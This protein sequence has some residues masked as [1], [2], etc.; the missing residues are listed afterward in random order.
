[1]EKTNELKESQWLIIH[2]DEN[3]NLKQYILNACNKLN[4]PNQYV[5][6]LCPV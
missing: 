5:I 4:H 2:R 6:T 1:M 3:Q